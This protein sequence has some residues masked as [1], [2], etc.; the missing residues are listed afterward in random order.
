M[1][2]CPAFSF[3]SDAISNWWKNIG[4]FVAK[5]AKVSSANIFHFMVV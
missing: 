1:N 3:F 2:V 4:E 5:F